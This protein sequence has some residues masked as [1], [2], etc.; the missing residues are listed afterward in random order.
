MNALSEQHRATLIRMLRTMFPHSSFPIG[1]YE[2][3]AGKITT[4]AAANPRLLAQLLQGLEDL[5]RLRPQPFA[6]L[7][8]QTA[9]TLLRGIQDTAFFRGVL[10]IA[11]VQFYDDHEVWDLLGYQGDS[12][13]KGGYL[14]RGF[15]DLD[16][17]PEPRTTEVENV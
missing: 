15:D 13:D 4:A 2:R 5:D 16:W 9:L 3:T 7:S 10:D 12:F 1:P 6:E 14:E 11:V 8:E 17:L